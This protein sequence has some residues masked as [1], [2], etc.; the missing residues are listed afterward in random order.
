MQVTSKTEYKTSDGNYRGNGYLAPENCCHLVMQDLC[1]KS[2]IFKKNLTLCHFSI[3]THTHTH[4][5]QHMHTQCG[6]ASSLKIPHLCAYAPHLSSP[7][8]ILLL[9]LCVTMYTVTCSKWLLGQHLSQQ[10]SSG[11]TWC[12]SPRTNHHKRFRRA[13]MFSRMSNY[14]CARL[15]NRPCANIR[16]WQHCWN[17]QQA[18]AAFARDRC[19]NFSSSPGS[20]R[21]SLRW[22]QAATHRSKRYISA[23]NAWETP[24]DLGGSLGA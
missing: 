20:N 18:S 21:K 9:K 23:W 17:H 15:I 24:R 10:L 22:V 12:L 16:Q 1:S 11:Q 19:P 4:T 3:S 2:W 7:R 5:L 13:E 6:C 8:L 14:I